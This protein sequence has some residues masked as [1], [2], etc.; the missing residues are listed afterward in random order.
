MRRQLYRIIN[1]TLVKEVNSDK[2]FGSPLRSISCQMGMAF[3]SNEIC[4]TFLKKSC[5]F[6]GQ[7]EPV[8]SK[9]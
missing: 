7:S 8:N 1:T 4:S 9:L 2:G 6:G 5:I 3:K